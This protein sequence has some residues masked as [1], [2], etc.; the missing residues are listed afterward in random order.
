MRHMNRACLIICAVLVMSSCTPVDDFGLYWD[1]GF[2]DP[3]LAGSWKKVL[4]AG[5][6][7]NFPCADRWRF[8]RSGTNYSLQS[9]N[10]IDPTA[11]PQDVAKQKADNERALSVRSLRIGKSLFLMRRDPADGGKGSI[12]RYEARRGVFNEYWIDNGAGVDF[13]QA[14]YPTATNIR[15]DADGSGYVVI[16]TFDDEVFRALSEIADN[17]G[18][19]L[20]VCSY[21]KVP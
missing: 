13:V 14:K 7:P 10:P 8:T 15:K 9:I 2:I 19:W 18:Y 20:P 16:G 12:V 17:P 1:K 6:D 11:D 5:E 21:K 4:R 3:A